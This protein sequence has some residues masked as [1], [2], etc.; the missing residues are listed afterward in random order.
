M[1]MLSHHWIRKIICCL[2]QPYDGKVVNNVT[3]VTFFKTKAWLPNFFKLCLVVKTG[4]GMH[5][6]TLSQSCGLKCHCWDL[7]YHRSSKDAQPSSLK[8]SI[9]TVRVSPQFVEFASQIQKPEQNFPAF[10]WRDNCLLNKL[11]ETMSN[12]SLFFILHP[13][14]DC[15]HFFIS[16]LGT[17]KNIFV[18]LLVSFDPLSMVD[19]LN[20]QWFAGTGK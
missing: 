7:V 17:L 4:T 5:Q 19:T 13:Q 15:F 11:P 16:C 9:H 3:S 14:M 2:K 18:Y 10:L 8:A 20:C 6:H 12:C 1:R